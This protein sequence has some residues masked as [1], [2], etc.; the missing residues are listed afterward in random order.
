MYGSFELSWLQLALLTAQEMKFSI[1]DLVTF[2]G[3][4]LNK[5]FHF[6]CSDF[7]PSIQAICNMIMKHNMKRFSSVTILSDWK[8][9]GAYLP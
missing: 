9:L 8:L 5:K 3:E 7:L 1:K 2:T 6:L 4:I